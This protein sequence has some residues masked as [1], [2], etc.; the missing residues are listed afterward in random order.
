[1]TVCAR[2]WRVPNPPGVLQSNPW[3]WCSLPRGHDGICH[4]AGVPKP[5]TALF[6]E[7]DTDYQAELE[8]ARLDEQKSISKKVAKKALASLQ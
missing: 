1:V 7:E 5:P 3:N 6:Y 8:K 4:S 2:S